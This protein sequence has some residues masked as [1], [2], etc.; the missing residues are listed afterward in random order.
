M[1]R[2]EGIGLIIGEAV[3]LVAVVAAVLVRTTV[4]AVNSASAI[5]ESGLAPI[6]T[7]AAVEAMDTGAAEAVPA[8]TAE[9]APAEETASATF[10]QAVSDKVASMTTEEKVAQLFVI[11]PEQLAHVGTVVATRDTM[12]EKI[13]QYPVGG[14]IYHAANIQGDDQAVQMF[15]NLQEV[16]NGRIGIACAV[17]YQ[18]GEG[19]TVD[20]DHIASLGINA[21]VALGGS[22]EALTFGVT[23]KTV[24]MALIADGTTAINAL[25]NGAICLDATGA[26]FEDTYNAVVAAVGND[27]SK[28]TLN[29]A[30]ET[31]LEGKGL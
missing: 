24:N 28:D 20:N 8:E 15:S 2:F 13:S 16:Y 19:E 9:A 31:V 23:G 27:L 1:R 25:K 22:P 21:A 29:Y 14:L 10:S 30:V 3:V 4:G 18:A 26:S 11:T 12:S 6:A 7:E 5:D 17:S